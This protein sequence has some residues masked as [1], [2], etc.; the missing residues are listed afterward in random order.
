MVKVLRSVVL[1]SLLGT[2]AQA[3]TLNE[4]PRPAYI[5]NTGSAY[6]QLNIGH[7]RALQ[8][9]QAIGS[10]RAQNLG[11]PHADL[12][13]LYRIAGQGQQE[14]ASVTRRIAALTGTEAL[15][16]SLKSRQRAQAKIS[17]ELGG[18]AGK[19]TD[20]V[21][22]SVIAD[23]I[24]GLLQAYAALEKHAAVVQVKNRFVDPTASGYRDL[25]VLVR[26]PESGL[27]AEVQFHLLRIAAVKNGPEHQLYE[28][29][30]R[31]ERRALAQQ[32][33]LTAIERAR[34]TQLR[35]TSRR[36]YLRAWQ[37][38]LPGLPAGQ[39]TS[40]SLSA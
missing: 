39:L 19:L 25:N 38:H 8:R 27:L 15:N 29:I 7:A 32:R 4:L 23:D 21:R 3:G 40:L 12:D 9:L 34:I 31:I 1:F 16:P 22:T 20:L 30:Q 6:G 33:S 24:P 35:D 28:Q 36:L 10:W 17:G 18:Q 37:H 2:S 11:Q 14:L 13:S 26:L 5:R